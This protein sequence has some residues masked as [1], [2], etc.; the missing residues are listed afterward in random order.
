AAKL[1]RVELLKPPKVVARNTIT[2]MQAGLIYGYAGMVDGLVGRIRAELEFPARCIATGGLAPLI[3][4]ETKTIEATD[5][6][7]TLKGLKIL[8]HRNIAS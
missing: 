5:E 4:T 7:L 2:S 8:Y 3:A 6:L 1:P